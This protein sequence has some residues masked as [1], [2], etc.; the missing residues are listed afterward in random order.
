M[1]VEKR[2]GLMRQIEETLDQDPP[3][4]LAGTG[5]AQMIWRNTVK[6]MALEKRR[7]LMYRGMETAWLDI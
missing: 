1:D 5:I 2:K 3:R 4:L 7:T 6:G